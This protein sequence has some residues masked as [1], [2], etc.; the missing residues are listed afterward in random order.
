MKTFRTHFLSAA[1][2]LMGIGTAYA[3]HADNTTAKKLAPQDG[4]IF[5]HSIG[6]CEKVAEC[7]TTPTVI[8]TVNGTP[9]GTQV[10]GL[11]VPENLSTCNV[12]LY[13]RQ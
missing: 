10:F 4:Y 2:I 13:Q 1:V 6:S 9:S 12:E 11:D 8:C 5:N 3:S 7:D